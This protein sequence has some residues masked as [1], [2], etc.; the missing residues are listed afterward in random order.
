[1]NEPAYRIARAVAAKVQ[2]HLA[3]HSA[4]RYTDN[5]APEPDIEA[6]EA[7]IDAG[8]WASLRREE[9][10]TPT[11]S[12]AFLPPTESGV[13][14]RLEHPLPLAAE[15][16][17]RLA[18]AVERPGVH[19]GVWRDGAELRVWGATRTLPAYCFV[20][21]VVAAGVL[22]VKHSRGEEAGKFANLA[23]LEGDQIKVLDQEA[24]RQPDTPSLLAFLLTLDSNG[25]GADSARALMQ[26]ALSMRAHRHGGTL[27][28]V[29][30]GS[31]Q[32]LESIVQPVRYSVAPAFSKL[33]ELMREPATK[34]HR[35]WEEALQ[36]T[37]DGI[38]GLTAVDGAMVITDRYELIAFGATIGRRAGGQR[39]E[40][41]VVLEPVEGSSPFLVPASQ[42]GGTRHLS[43]AQFVLDQRDTQALVASK[44]GRFTLF[45]WSDSREMVQAH[46][47][48]ALLL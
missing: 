34:R 25:P 48:D 1:M 6:I 29:P 35:Q 14:L 8:F 38:A 31:Q 20:L 17:T 2:Q 39:V 30:S 22:V 18:P 46:R 42:L 37:V 36:R 45:S 32:W 11:I 41:V 7:I 13:Q 16:L 12:L 5:R 4:G 28:V 15:P 47:L 26:L 23:V 33:A 27:L 19:L 40:Q 9:G 43:A 44:D 10:V 3:R 21:E 24:A